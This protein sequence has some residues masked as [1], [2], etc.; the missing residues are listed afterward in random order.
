MEEKVK[1]SDI[2]R[3]SGVSPATVSLV[4]NNKPGVAK[5]TRVRV[6]EIAEKLEYPI[7]PVGLT[8]LGGQLTTIGMVVKID[9]IHPLANPFYSK[10]IAGIEDACR[11]HGINLL[12]AT[13]PV[14]ENNPV[15]QLPHAALT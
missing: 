3:Q 8:G 12:F 15:V 4:L 13:L 10:V 14:D 5:E 9:T 1:I 2:A 6:L 11:K 7:K